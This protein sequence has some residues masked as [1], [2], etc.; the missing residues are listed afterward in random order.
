MRREEFFG[1]ATVFFPEEVAV[2]TVIAETKCRVLFIERSVLETIME[3]DFAIASAYIAFLSERIY[4]LNRK[5]IAF[6][7]RNADAAFAGYLLRAA[8]GNGVLA[9]NMSRIASTLGIGR[10]TIYRAVDALAAEG[11]IAHD[12][13]MIRILNR[14]LLEKKSKNG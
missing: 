3:N 9:A 5:I 2:S 10:T 6:T 4:F 7:A 14:E 12:G 8:D 1:A 13:K 11:A